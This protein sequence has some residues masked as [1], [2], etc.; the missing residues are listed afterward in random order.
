MRCI[1]VVAGLMGVVMG[2]APLDVAR[3][4]SSAS[5]TVTIT[6][7]P[8][9][10]VAFAP[11]PVVLTARTP[12]VTSGVGSY[13]FATTEAGQ[14]IVVDLDRPMPVGATLTVRMGPPRTKSEGRVTALHTAA[15]DVVT[16]IEPTSSVGGLPIAYMVRSTRALSE[17]GEQR[18]LTYTVIASS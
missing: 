15:M 8:A 7:A 12:G 11:S 10:R 1:G 18:L 6:V 9:N 14:K 13:R 2:C 17:A 3:A 5:H 4:Q 16:A